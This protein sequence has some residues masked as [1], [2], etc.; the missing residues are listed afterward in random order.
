M[1]LLQ[2]CPPRPKWNLTMSLICHFGAGAL[3]V[4]VAGVFLGHH[5]VATKTKEAEQIPTVSVDHSFFGQPEDAAHNTLPVLIVRDRRS[6]GICSHPVPPKGV[7][8][9]CLARALMADLDFMGYKRII[10]MSDQEPIIIALY[11]AVNNGWHGEIV[12]RSI[13]QGRE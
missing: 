6:R 3:R 8:H 4:F 7:M 13:C 1:C 5:K 11:D 10:L 9:P 2:F 12:P